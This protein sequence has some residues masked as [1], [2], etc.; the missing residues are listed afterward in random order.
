[1]SGDKRAPSLDE[2]YGG[3]AVIEGVMMRD[4]HSMCIAVRTPEG[5]I[6]TER[7]QLGAARRLPLLRLPIMRGMLA[8]Y[9]SVKLG[10][11][12]LLWSAEVSG[13]P[14]EQLAGWQVA[15]TMALSLAISV[16]LFMLLPTLIVSS[17]RS[18]MHMA[19]TSK[20]RPD[21]RPQ[22][23]RR[24]CPCGDSGVVRLADRADARHCPGSAVSRGGASRHPYRGSGRGPDSG[25]SAGIR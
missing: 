25:G 3:Q 21:R 13:E 9:D 12:A 2:T 7:K 24:H 23:R 11:D 8:L 22:Y 16:G 18:L 1:M 5:G 4:R 14:E 10:I 15:L 19:P 17:L 6:T 20:L